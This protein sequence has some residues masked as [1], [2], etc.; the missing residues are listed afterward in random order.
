MIALRAQS[1][2]FE[3]AR[4]LLTSGRAE[5]AAAIFRELSRRDPG[6][7]DMLLNLSIAEYKAGDFDKAAKS[8]AAALKIAP[9]QTSAML[10]LGAA[11]LQLGRFQQA[12]AQLQRVVA[13]NGNDR[14]ARL[15]LADALAGANR[16]ADAAA[17]Y[18]AVSRMLPDNARV[19]YGLGRT[20]EAMGD[21]SAAAN[22]WD[23]LNKLPPSPES[24]MHAAEK[25]D[26]ALRWRAAASEWREALTLDE[27]NTR[28][29]IG[30]AWSLFRS[31]DYEGTL[32]ALKPLMHD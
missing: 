6:N 27:Q 19:W 25:H 22:A 10:F 16:L 14:N 7:A 3:R 21:T 32:A 17:Q 5:E 29:R 28:A 30:L 24:H 18:Q 9:D 13:L 12:V 8:A 31:R 11:D 4:N 20:Y 2:D 1:T 23:K 15:M 26:A